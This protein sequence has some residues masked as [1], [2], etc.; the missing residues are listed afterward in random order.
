MFGSGNNIDLYDEEIGYRDCIIQYKYIWYN[1]TTCKGS[2]GQEP[3]QFSTQY[4]RN[5]RLFYRQ[6]H[7]FFFPF[8][9]LFERVLCFKIP[10]QAIEK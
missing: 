8:D 2:N 6:L 10:K 5:A 3:L 1:R 4:R 9:K 7:M